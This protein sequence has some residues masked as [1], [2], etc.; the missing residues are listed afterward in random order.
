MRTLLQPLW[1]LLCWLAS[2][3]GNYMLTSGR[4]P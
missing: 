4:K 2:G 3:G 1:R